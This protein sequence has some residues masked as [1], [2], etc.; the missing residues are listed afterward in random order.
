MEFSR[1]ELEMALKDI[2]VLF[3][4]V[5]KDDLS[6]SEAEI[7]MILVQLGLLDND[8]ADNQVLDFVV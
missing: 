5:N 2:A 4:G 8:P 6:F 3:Q 7:V 1:E